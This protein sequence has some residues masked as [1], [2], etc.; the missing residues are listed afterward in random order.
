ML[1][2]L[3]TIKKIQQ[4][5]FHNLVVFA[6]YLLDRYSVRRYRTGTKMAGDAEIDFVGLSQE[7]ETQELEVCFAVFL[8]LTFFS[9]TSLILEILSERFKAA[10]TEEMA[11]WQFAALPSQESSTEYM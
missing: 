6:S 5:L 2:N 9:T 11:D 4:H 3:V 7:L 10:S 1:F 8:S